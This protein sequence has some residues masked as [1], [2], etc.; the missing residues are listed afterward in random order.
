MLAAIRDHFKERFAEWIIGTALTG[1]G[2]VVLFSPGVFETS[3]NFATMEGIASRSAW[4]FVALSIGLIRLAFLI[5]NGTWQRSAHLRAIGAGLSAC[6]WA[7]MLGSYLALDF[8]IPNIFT[9]G[10]LLAADIFS[11]WFASADAKL[12]DL[13][14]KDKRNDNLKT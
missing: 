7:A 2:L 12:S 13:W 9:I 5:I 11:L 14:H 1:W 8:L 10:A 6:F 3:S 4:G